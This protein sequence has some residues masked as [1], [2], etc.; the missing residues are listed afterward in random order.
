MWQSRIEIVYY[1]VA[2][3]DCVTAFKA[4]YLLTFIKSGAPMQCIVASIAAAFTQRI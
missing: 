4:L 3:F 1:S 2:L